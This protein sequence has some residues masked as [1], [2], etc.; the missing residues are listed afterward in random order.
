MSVDTDTIQAPPETAVELAHRSADGFEITLL[1]HERTDRLAVV[2]VDSRTGVSFALLT[3]DGK[4]A[5]DAFYHPFAYAAAR[6]VDSYP[7]QDLRNVEGGLPALASSA[8]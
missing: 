5:L 7:E 8:P 2:V 4:E 1:W 3:A 6:G